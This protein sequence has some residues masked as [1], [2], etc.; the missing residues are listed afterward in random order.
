M[1]VILISLCMWLN[2]TAAQ[3]LPQVSSVYLGKDTLSG[4]QCRVQILSIN[5]EMIEILFSVTA[6]NSNDVIHLEA[7]TLDRVMPHPLVRAD[8]E[9]REETFSPSSQLNTQNVTSRRTRLYWGN[10]SETHAQYLNLEKS[11]Q[12][13]INTAGNYMTTAP[14]FDCPRMIAQ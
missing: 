10:S 6:K 11:V 7:L 8:F 1:R 4:G 2:V 14:L 5:S 3:E 13:H 12:F 9:R